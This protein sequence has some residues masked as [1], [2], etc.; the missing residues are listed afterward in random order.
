MTL[1]T[2]PVAQNVSPEYSTGVFLPVPVP[3]L[4]SFLLPVFENSSKM[5]LAW[6]ARSCVELDRGGM[7]GEGP[8]NNLLTCAAS[9]VGSTLKTWPHP[10]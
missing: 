4:D 5:P 3:V 8:R 10:L 2:V 1:Q 6:I 7:R 9:S